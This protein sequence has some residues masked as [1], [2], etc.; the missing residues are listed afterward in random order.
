MLGTEFG[1][2]TC[3]VSTVQAGNGGVMWGIFSW[4]TLIPAEHHF[5]AMTYQNIVA[6]HVHHIFLFTI[7]PFYNGYIQQDNAPCHKTQ[8][9][10]TWVN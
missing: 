2:P 10:S 3:L 8:V 6:N 7:Y 4:H 9:V 5:N 1:I